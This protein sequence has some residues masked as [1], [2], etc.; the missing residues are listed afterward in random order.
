[1]TIKIP[2]E[3]AAKLAK[4]EV[5]AGTAHQT[6]ASAASRIGDLQRAISMNPASESADAIRLELKE[7]AS[8]RDVQAA[9]HRDL[10]VTV[11]ACRQ[12]LQHLA[13]TRYDTVLEVVKTQARPL[14]NE[15][16]PQAI[17]RVR[18]EI[19]ATK[20]HLRLITI[21]PLPRDDIKKMASEYLDRLARG[22][23]VETIVNA[24]NVFE[25]R[26][27]LSDAF[28]A[29]SPTHVLSLL[30]WLDR[31]AVER[32]FAE[33][34][35]AMPM[36]AEPIGLEEKKRR[37]GDLTANLERSERAEETLICAALDEGLP[38]KR[39]HDASPQAVLGVRIGK[40]RA[41]PVKAAS[42]P[43]KH[44]LAEHRP[45]YSAT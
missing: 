21:A 16:L 1:M 11:S 24:H 37:T 40:A 7:L 12:W 13:A 33:L 26:I 8:V 14:K 17:R 41:E 43:K 44:F 35:D 5:A 29:M 27:T 36:A 45:E 32:R 25:P 10:S 28:G 23:R 2:P 18:D 4:L 31:A 22:V 38:V 3:A 15:T 20:Q 6:A 42:E 30:A 19:I 34:V 39:R 9:L